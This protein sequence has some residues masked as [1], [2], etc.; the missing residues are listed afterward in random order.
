MDVDN[1][2]APQLAK[3]GGNRPFRVLCLHGF[4]QT[5]ASMAA[6]VQPI[7]DA[8]R[9][10]TE[11]VIPP[12][13]DPWWR[14]S[15]LLWPA[16]VGCESSLDFLRVFSASNGPFDGVLGFSQGACLAGMLCAMQCNASMSAPITVRFAVVCSGFCSRDAQHNSLYA[17]TLAIPS[18][19]V[20]GQNDFVLLR[21]FASSLAQCFVNATVSYHP[22]GH[23]LPSDINEIVQFIRDKCEQLPAKSIAAPTPAAAAAAAAAIEA[24]AATA[25]NVS[26]RQQRV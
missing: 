6:M 26:Q 15:R 11:L 19:H 22:G 21:Y 5:A 23:E 9:G 25:A 17:P 20:V 7:A 18:L 8:L 10:H 3:P 1:G 2:C 12:H 4:G 24:E 16:Y 14:A 13:S